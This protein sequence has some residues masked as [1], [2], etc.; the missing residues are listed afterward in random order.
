M[1]AFPDQAPPRPHSKRRFWR[2]LYFRS[3]CLSALTVSITIAVFAWAMIR[4]LKSV[5]YNE[6]TVQSEV[7][8]RSIESQIGKDVAL[9]DQS[10]VV[11]KCKQY[12]EENDQVLYTVVTIRGNKAIIQKQDGEWS[13]S[14]DVNGWDPT[15]NNHDYNLIRPSPFEAEQSVFQFSHPIIYM[16]TVRV[17]WIHVG[18]ST[19]TYQSNL[20]M[21]Y[22]QTGQF[23]LLSLALGVLCSLLFTRQLT[24]PIAKLRRFASDLAE[25]HL[26]QQV[27]IRS[28]DEIGELAQRMNWMAQSIYRSQ[29]DLAVAMT[30]ENAL[31]EKEILLREIHHRVKNNMQILASLIRIQNR[32]VKDERVK[33]VLSESETRIRS[34][35]L[36]HKKLYQSDSISDIAFGPYIKELCQELQRLYGQDAPGVE[37]Q[38]HIPNELKF[39]L[40][41]ALPCGLIINEIVSNSFKYG[42]PNRKSGKIWIRLDTAD[43][44]LYELEVGDNGVGLAPEFDIKN[45]TSLGL[46]LV[47]MLSEQLQGE[48]LINRDEGVAFLIRLRPPHYIERVPQTTQRVIRITR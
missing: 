25:G 24:R 23:S 7:I 1:S 32:S 14:H 12:M 6:L 48:L 30:H 43:D 40:D 28:K 13:V 16:S 42:F 34:M 8:A 46:R 21:I 5:G 17:G 11:A 26:E 35:A 15:S 37:I 39:S 44:G 18:V 45:A 2:S 19:K 22:Q 20:A 33:A 27:N 9:D 29:E 4:Y 47:Q 3:A 36:L 31:R 38:T 10:S 41:T